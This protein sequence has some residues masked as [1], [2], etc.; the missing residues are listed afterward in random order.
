MENIELEYTYLL[1]PPT[2]R[3]SS[4]KPSL[5]YFGILVFS[6]S[7]SPV[8]TICCREEEEGCARIFMDIFRCGWPYQPPLE[9]IFRAANSN[10]HP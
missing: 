3:K 1:E 10:T 8:S 2:L 7:T 5:P 6:D 9:I 4:L